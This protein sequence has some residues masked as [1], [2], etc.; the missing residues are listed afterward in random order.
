MLTGC[1]I[2]MDIVIIITGNTRRRAEMASSCELLIAT[3]RGHGDPQFLKADRSGILE[4]PLLQVC[5][6]NQ[7]LPTSGHAS[8]L[9][10]DAFTISSPQLGSLPNNR[11]DEFFRRRYGI[12]G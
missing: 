1:A 6:R 11:T 8:P 2:A 5:V 10:S 9:N 12:G 4:I 7:K 3:P